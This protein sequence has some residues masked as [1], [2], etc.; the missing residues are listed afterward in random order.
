MENAGPAIA[1]EFFLSVPERYHKPFGEAGALGSGTVTVNSGGT[2]GSTYEGQSG[3][4]GWNK[5]LSLDGLVSV[6]RHDGRV[7]AAVQGIILY[8]E[9]GPD[10][11][12]CARH[13]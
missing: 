13:E 8:Y 1:G 3:S 5:G 9:C 2:L 4:F 12:A 7:Q 11:R 6:R 10:L